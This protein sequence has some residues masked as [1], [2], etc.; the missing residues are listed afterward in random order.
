MTIAGPFWQ[1]RR[2]WWE[3]WRDHS[4]SPGQTALATS[5]Y[6]NIVLIGRESNNFESECFSLW[7][8]PYWWS[9]TA[10][11]RTWSSSPSTVSCSIKSARTTA[12][13]VVGEVSCDLWFHMTVDAS[14]R[15]A[16]GLTIMF[17]VRLSM[18]Q[19][20]LL[21]VTTYWHLTKWQD[22]IGKSQYCFH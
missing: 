4:L 19:C 7:G 1:Y 9:L 21:L 5:Y 17:C 20:P 3:R 18:S 6:R 12:P 15:V 22:V 13:R 10:T 2:P 16:I 14:D 8:Q 11:L